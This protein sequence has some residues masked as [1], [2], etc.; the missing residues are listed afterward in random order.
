MIEANLLKLG[1]VIEPV[2][3]MQFFNFSFKG[4]ITAKISINN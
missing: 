3:G 4:Q 1:G 2:S